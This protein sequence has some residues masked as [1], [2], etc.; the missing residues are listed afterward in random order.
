M[1]IMQMPLLC[2]TISIMNCALY[3]H[4]P[5]CARKCLYC[6]FISVPFTEEMAQGY[7]R[8]LCNELTLRKDLA[9]PLDTVYIGGG[10]PSLLGAALFSGLFDC[11]SDTCI[12]SS[13]AEITVEANPGTVDSNTLDVLLSR[14]ANRLSIGVQSFQDSELKTLGRIHTADEAERA[15]AVVKSSGFINISLDLMYGIPGQ[16][17]SS[18]KDSLAKAVRSAPTHIS[19]YQLTPEKKTPLYGLLS[20]GRLDLLDEDLIIDMYHYAIDFLGAHGYGHYE[21]SNFALPGRACRHNLNYWNRG[22]YAG[23]GA[24]AHS[25]IDSSRFYNT[26]DVT[27]YVAELSAGRL[28]KT[29]EK[30]LTAGEAIQEC[31]FL[32]L[33]KTT[34]ICLSDLLLSTVDITAAS[35]DLARQGYLNI[36]DGYLHLTRQGMLVS[37][38]VIVKLLQAL[39]L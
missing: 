12:I 13:E 9:T 4:I 36:D 11:I 24:G 10:T 17:M 14:G 23:V 27:E 33:R 15:I 28:P 38:M 31:I 39:N 29:Q 7:I 26:G 35:Q 34:G 8:A 18:W 6:D 2:H 3:I 1:G 30:T 25:F 22:E 5:F 21:V 37:N 20:S 16:S 32:G 19:A